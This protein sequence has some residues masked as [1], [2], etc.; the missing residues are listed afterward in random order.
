[1]M[2]VRAVSAPRSAGPW[3][4]VAIGF[5]ALA[6]AFSTRSSI[7]LTIP[8]WEK[9]FGWTRSFISTGGAITMIVTAA[10]APVAGNLMDRYGPR[11]LLAVGLAL[12]GAAA[13]LVAVMQSAW[14]YVVAFGIVGGLGFGIAA[15]HT[16]STA[17]ARL[18]ETR[19]GLAIGIATA[20]STAGQL[21]LMPTL[22]FLHQTVSW[23]WGFAAIAVACAVLAPV[24]WFR[25][26]GAGGARAAA[27]PGEAGI[28]PLRV[29]LRFL[30]RH[31]VFHALFGSF[32]VCGFTTAGVI[33]VHLLPYAAACGFPPLPSSAAYG[34][35]AA[36]NLAGMIFSG[37][38]TDR[39]HRP[40][41]L[42]TIYF[43]RALS[44][45]LLLYIVNDIALLFIFAVMFGVFDYGTVPVTAS[46]AAQHLGIKV[47]GLAMG[48]IAAGHALGGA[49][50][51]F[52][53]GYLF[54]LFASYQWVWLASVALAAMAGFM[55]L[56]IPEPRGRNVTPATA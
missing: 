29:R 37:W 56:T 23:R 10:M 34:V 14:L 52:L 40:T 3:A 1:M 46:L 28:E 42:A 35:L 12:V 25:L 44:F 8:F 26:R 7:G 53:G 11:A 20:G 27:K 18:F 19:R 5:V 4:V 33:E 55:V 17:V 32:F 48:L 31:P 22:A 24:A 54:D 50:G 21:F 39:V 2:D 38:L 41:W 36:F 30:L 9:D 51:A 15:Q 16:V 47:M 49:L 45:V 13:A 6:L 43:G